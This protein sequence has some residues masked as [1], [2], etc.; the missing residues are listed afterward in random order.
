MICGVLVIRYFR[1]QSDPLDLHVFFDGVH[2]DLLSPSGLSNKNVGVNA[3]TTL[4]QKKRERAAV[5]DQ[6]VIWPA[7]K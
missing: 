1:L 7:E 2:D 6:I 4:G 5:Q 3:G